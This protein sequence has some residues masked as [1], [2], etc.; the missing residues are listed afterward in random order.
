MRIVPAAVAA[1]GLLIAARADAGVLDRL[2]AG[3]ALRLGFREDAAPYAYRAEGG[4]PAGYSIE[5][6]NRV[7]ADLREQLSL[8]GLK[9]EYVPVT[10][11][12]R[13]TAVEDGSIDLECGS[14][15]ATLSRRKSVDFSIPTFID[16][17]S[18]LYRAGGPGALED[19]GGHKI[20]VH[21]GTTTE[22]LLKAT[23]D[24]LGV[25]A[26]VVSVADHK[27]GLAKLK[28]GDVT[29]YFADQSILLFLLQQ[30][31]ASNE[32][33]LSDRFFTREPY[34][35]MLPRGDEDF[36]LFVDTSLSRL[37]RSGD[38]GAVFASSF[39]KAKPS[40]LLEALYQI[41]PLPE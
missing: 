30:S 36:R 11:D 40:A 35:L 38:I 39:G 23:L 2:K 32:L 25:D 26:E 4:E 20:A 21:S 37:Y 17:A 28:Q 5:L 15:T 19:L 27:E 1:I 14:T 6:C 9:V 31:G 22:K 34:A 13:F 16:G 10:A 12:S 29:A 24:H 8:P 41:A 7:A 33:K 18:V 3:E